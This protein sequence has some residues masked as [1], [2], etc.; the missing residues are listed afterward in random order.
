MAPLPAIILIMGLVLAY[1][2]PITREFHAEIR[3]KLKEREQQ[4]DNY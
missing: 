4:Q 1:F 2:Y 3:L